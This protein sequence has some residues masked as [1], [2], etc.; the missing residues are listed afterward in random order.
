MRGRKPL[1]SNVVKLR[2]NPGKRRPNDAEPQPA[3]KTPPCP[4]C[5]GE[6]ARKEWK[7]GSSPIL[8]C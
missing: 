8:V 5:L 2:G 6:E 7:P 3:A 1:P 4:A